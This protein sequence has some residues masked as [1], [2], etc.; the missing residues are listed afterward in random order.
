MQCKDNFKFSQLL[1]QKCKQAGRNREAIERGEKA[2]EAGEYAGAAAAP[3][4]RSE[5]AAVAAEKAEAAARG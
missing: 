2:A 5:A 3:L 4:K 1:L